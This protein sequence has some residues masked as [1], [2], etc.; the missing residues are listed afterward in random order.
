MMERKIQ[1]KSVNQHIT[2]RLCKGYLIDATTITEC[3]HTFCKSCLVKYLDDNNSCPTCE[4]VIHQSHPLNFISHDRT[5]Q[6]IVYKLVPNLQENEKKKQQEFYR[7]RG[8][9][10]PKTLSNN[11]EC[12]NQAT[13][14]QD[15]HRSDE[16]VNICLECKSHQMK[17]L[18]RKF[19]RCSINATIT[20]IKKFVA[21]KV[22]NNTCRY[23]DVDILCNDEILGKDHTLK[24][25]AV[26]RWRQKDVPLLL[27][28]RQRI[29]L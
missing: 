11:E 20:H 1:L 22:L 13:E 9:P 3:L 24:F 17:T 26:T 5:M 8:I 14:D 19:I 4:I 12:D 21:L 29:D 28:Y 23:K 27:H 2:C 7:S 16:Q 15:C 25:V 6:D 18:K 10:F